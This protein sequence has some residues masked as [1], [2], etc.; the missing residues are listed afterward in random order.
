MCCLIRFLSFTLYVTVSRGLNC[1]LPYTDILGV[2]LKYTAEGMSWCNAQIYCYSIGGELVRGNNFLPLSGKTFPG[3]P[4]YWIGLTD[5]LHERRLNTS[6]WR[7]TDGSVDPPSSELIW[8]AADSRGFGGGTTDCVMQRGDGKVGD[9]FCYNLGVPMCQPRP[10]LSSA[11]RIRNFDVVA[12]P[13]GLAKEEYT[14]QGCALGHSKLRIRKVPSALKCGTYCNMEP[15]DACVS[16]YYNKANRQ[17]ILVFFTDGTYN[18]ESK[19]DNEMWRK[20]LRKN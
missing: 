8:V 9:R 20:Y 7:W 17:C 19:N 2:C 18:I 12:L 5:Y 3:M 13:R 15:N 4:Q 11:P 16:F 14:L 10:P 1:V 6:G